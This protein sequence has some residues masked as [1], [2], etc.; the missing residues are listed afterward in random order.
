MSSRFIIPSSIIQDFDGE[1]RIRDIDLAARLGMKQPLNIRQS[2]KIH[3]PELS[4][5]GGVFMQAVKTSK[6][7]GRPGSAYFLNEPQCLLLCM[8]A[9]TTKAADVR[10]M[11]IDLF[12]AWR[13]GKL[14]DV[15]QHYRQPPRALGKI[16]AVGFNLV[17]YVSGGNAF[18]TLELPMKDAITLMKEVYDT[19]PNFRDNIRRRDGG[20]R[21]ERNYQGDARISFLKTELE[22]YRRTGRQRCSRQ[23]GDRNQRCAI[24]Q[25]VAWVLFRPAIIA[26]DDHIASG[27]QTTDE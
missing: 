24:G 25:A 16:R 4:L 2:I 10:K 1:P 5:H 13:E 26:I 18:L 15:R 3:T 9:N 14:V 17:Q 19:W 8:W 20:Q 12:M 23:V 21:W 7:G 22:R 6:K 27:S 11:L